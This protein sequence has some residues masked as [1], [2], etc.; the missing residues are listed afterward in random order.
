MTYELF[1]V[2]D[3]MNLFQTFFVFISYNEISRCLLLLVVVVVVLVV[4]YSLFSNF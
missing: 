4:C 3:S 1:I 2:I